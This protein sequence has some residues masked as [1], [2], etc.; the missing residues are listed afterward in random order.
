MKKIRANPLGKTKEERESCFP[1]SVCAEI[2][3][4]SRK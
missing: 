4:G 3:E 2:R 1:E